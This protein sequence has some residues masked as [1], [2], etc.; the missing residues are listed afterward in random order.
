M[1]DRS[2]L[3]FHSPTYIY[4]FIFIK[5]EIYVHV[6]YD[7]FC[8]IPS[9]IILNINLLW[10]RRHRNI[11]VFYLHTDGILLNLSKHFSKILGTKNFNLPFLEVFLISSLILVEGKSECW[12]LFVSTSMWF[13]SSSQ[14]SHSWELSYSSCCEL[15][16]PLFQLSLLM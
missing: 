10:W 7:S 9:Y 2:I 12:T 11:N 16:F 1:K 8:Q 4:K 15:D 5:Y 6:Y 14:N 13:F 3:C